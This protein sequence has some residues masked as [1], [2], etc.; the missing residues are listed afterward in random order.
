MVFFHRLYRDYIEKLS[1]LHNI[2][3]SK[4][5]MG[6]FMRETSAVL[7]SSTHTE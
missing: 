2:C 7:C 6:D 5:I 3:V 1:Q 4:G